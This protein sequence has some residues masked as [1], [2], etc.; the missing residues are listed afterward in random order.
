MNLIE[1]WEGSLLYSGG[2]VEDSGIK[3]KS[4]D[5]SFLI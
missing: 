2:Q 1:Y 3:T 5:H 4:K